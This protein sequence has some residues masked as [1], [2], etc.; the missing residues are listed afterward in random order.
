MNCRLQGF[1]F[2]S[3]LHQLSSFLSTSVYFSLPMS[4]AVPSKDKV[5]FLPVPA[6]IVEQVV[7][8]DLFI[9]QNVSST[10]TLV[11]H[12]ALLYR[13]WGRIRPELPMSKGQG[14]SEIFSMAAY[15]LRWT[16]CFQF[17]SGWTES[18][19][20]TPVAKSRAKW[21][22]RKMRLSAR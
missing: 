12:K 7:S 2:V 6:V 8:Y 5:L 16:L 19:S 17:N 18:L 1:L 22:L 20:S 9:M 10:S 4:K 13:V 21:L 15:F 11:L 14:H 3:M